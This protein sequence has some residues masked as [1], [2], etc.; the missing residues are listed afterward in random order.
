RGL[1][2]SDIYRELLPALNSGRVEL[3]DVPRLVSQLTGLERRTSRGGRDSIDHAPGGHDDLANATGS[4]SP[5]RPSRRLG[6][7]LMAGPPAGD[8]RRASMRRSAPAR[9]YG[10]RDTREAVDR[11]RARGRSG[12]GPGSSPTRRTRAGRSPPREGGYRARAARAASG[13]E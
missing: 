2:K 9:G 11:S 1:V 5:G 13:S 8:S 4:P 3:L 6:L 10:R 12:S 7:Q